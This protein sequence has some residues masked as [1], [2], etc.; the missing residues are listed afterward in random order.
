ML[1]FIICTNGETEASSISS[2]MTSTWEMRPRK[3]GGGKKGILAHKID[4]CI[5]L[6]S[7]DA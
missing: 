2:L 6:F 3:G 1:L 5:V 7:T 4:E